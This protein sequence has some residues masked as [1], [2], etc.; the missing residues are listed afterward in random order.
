MRRSAWSGPCKGLWR[1]GR[2]EKGDPIR[3]P[4]VFPSKKTA[5]WAVI[6]NEAQEEDLGQSDARASKDFEFASAVAS[7]G[8][9]LR[10]S[11]YKGNATFDSVLELA[12]EGLGPDRHGYRAEFMGLVREAKRLAR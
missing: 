1:S 11:S 6:G 10:D 3:L 9:I 7:F 12:E 4:G 5:S 8:M 2:A